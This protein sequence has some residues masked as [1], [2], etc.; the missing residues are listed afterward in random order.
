MVSPILIGKVPSDSKQPQ[1]DLAREDFIVELMVKKDLAFY[2]QGLSL[3]GGRHRYY[4][5]CPN[6][7]GRFANEYI[8]VI[9]RERLRSDLI[10]APTEE[11]IPLAAAVAKGLG[12]GVLCYRHTRDGNLPLKG[13]TLVIVCNAMTREVTVAATAFAENEALVGCVIAFDP[14]EKMDRS[15]LSAIQ[16]FRKTFPHV[17]VHTL[18]RLADLVSV[19]V[20]TASK[21]L[22]PKGRAVLIGN[23]LAQW[24]LNQE[25]PNK[26]V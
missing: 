17:P 23:I 10:F 15:D 22:D 4:S 3:P 19:L 24:R 25:D 5:F 7:M 6:E 2:P 21:S 18:A 14:Q 11:D 9:R 1:G 26:K 16:E 12:G 13:K 8:E 20:K